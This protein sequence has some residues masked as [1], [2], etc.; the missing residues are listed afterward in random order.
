MFFIDTSV[1]QTRNFSS[2]HGGFSISVIIESLTS[3]HS[4]LLWLRCAIIFFEEWKY[5]I[6]CGTGQWYRFCFALRVTDST[7]VWILSTYLC[8]N[9]LS[10]FF[11]IHRFWAD[12]WQM[13]YAWNR[14]LSTTPQYYL[15][16]SSMMPSIFWIPRGKIREPG[17][18]TGLKR[19]SHLFKIGGSR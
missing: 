12:Q 2:L 15:L 8:C 6:A 17:R 19:N 4:M 13:R 10:I 7:E 5:I 14:I 16:R 3:Y 1:I 9:I 11:A 18:G